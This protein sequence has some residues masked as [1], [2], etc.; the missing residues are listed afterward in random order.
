MAAQSSIIV[1]EQFM[2][3]SMSDRKIR[4]RKKAR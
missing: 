4:N 3:H 2:K 1:P